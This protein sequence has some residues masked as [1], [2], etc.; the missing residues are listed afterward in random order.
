VQKLWRGV[1]GTGI[2]LT[3]ALVALLAGVGVGALTEHLR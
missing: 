2:V 1:R 3:V